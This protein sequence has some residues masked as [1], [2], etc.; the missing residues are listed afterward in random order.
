MEIQ[1]RPSTKEDSSVVHS[2]MPGVN[3][4]ESTPPEKYTYNLT[5]TKKSNRGP[6]ILPKGYTEDSSVNSLKRFNLSKVNAC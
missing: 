1:D 3:I 6:G 2:G 5:I 4:P